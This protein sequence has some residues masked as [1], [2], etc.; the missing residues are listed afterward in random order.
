MSSPTSASEADGTSAAFGRLH[1]RLQRW[2]HEQGWTT[3]HD[4]QE[5]AI[6]PI[7]D[8][9]RDVII[10]A[11]TAAG[12]TEAAFL[13][14]CSALATTVDGI[15]AAPPPD[16]WAGHD[17]WTPPPTAPPTGIEVLYVSPLKALINDQYDRLELLCERAG[18]PVHRWHGDVASNAK[19]KVR[20]NPS[21]VLLITPESLEATFVNRGS[22]APT[23]FGGIRY[24]VIDELHSFLS[25]PRGAQLQSLLARVELAIR[26]RPPRI[27]LSATLGDMSAAARFLRPTAPDRVLMIDSSN[28]ALN[29]KLQMRGYR[30]SA[31]QLSGREAAAVEEGGGEVQVEETVGGDR[32]EIA[33]HLF[34]TLRGTDNLVFANARR[35]VE[36]YADLLARRCD[37]ERLPNEFW[38]HHGS[39]AKDVREVVEAQLKDRARPVTAVCTSTLEMGIDIGTVS[40][41]AQVGPPPS[42]ASLR[43]RL[44]RSG[45]RGEAPVVRI[46][47]TEDE[48][49]AQMSPID[50][51]RPHVVHTVAMV[52]LLLARWVEPPVDPGL[53]LSTL[54]QQTLSVIA[55]HGGATAKDLHGA[56]CGP[57]PFEL[58]D[59]SRFGALLRAMA[60]ADMIVQ[61]SDGTLLHGRVGERVVN[62]YSFYTAFQTPE[63]WKLIAD[64]RNLGT[65][66]IVQ[67][68]IEGGLLIFGGRR[69][70]I[71]GIDPDARIVE[72]TR[73]AGGVPPNFGG[74]AALIGDRVRDE[75]VAVYR[76][77]DIP[78]WL[79]T[80]AKALLGEGRAAWVRYELDSRVLIPAG[81]GSIILPWA[82]D[83]ALMTAA[84]QLGLLDIEAGKSG[85]ALELPRCST[86]ELVA[87]VC[88]LLNG[89][90]PDALDIA[91]QLDNTEI[92]KWDWVLDKE[93]GAQATAARLLDVDG[94]WDIFERISVPGPAPP[95]RVIVPYQPL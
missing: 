22:T 9:N 4:A 29:L 37:A 26:R 38:P 3:L 36:V 25:T 89:P 52:R 19:Q 40:S 88:E 31:A 85:P 1:P 24:V 33:D 58:V 41:V 13:P 42:V 93:L 83:Q 34:M 91:R 47:V 20:Q 59:A 23:F 75:M 21:G 69:W 57:G 32:L 68:L 5:R 67:P 70:R 60:A 16:P 65:L 94:A 73:S 62:H 84:L 8:G 18:V 11:A 17:P 2:V 55:Q 43:Q 12:K 87:S 86:E 10:S 80:D 39:L 54:I 81:K 46:Y 79:N 76:G 14:I 15:A 51:L 92:D 82:G 64:G 78:E 63:E 90:R 7:L 6:I 30:H 95:P 72:L 49:S 53:N 77:D 56:L 61:S 50:E 74:D 44:G 48:L 66:P 45:R 27:G 35:E 28:T 71:T